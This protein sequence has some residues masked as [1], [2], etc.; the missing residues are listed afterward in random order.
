MMKLILGIIVTSIQH[1]K[2][3]VLLQAECT[4]AV[5]VLEELGKRSDS[6][7]DILVSKCL[8]TLGELMGIFILSPSAS[9][10]DCLRVFESAI[11]FFATTGYVNR[12][13]DR[14]DMWMAREEFMEPSGMMDMFEDLKALKALLFSDQATRTNDTYH[15]VFKYI[16]AIV[17]NGITYSPVLR[18]NA[19]FFLELGCLSSQLHSSAHQGEMVNTALCH[20][21]EDTTWH[22]MRWIAALAHRNSSE[23]MLVSEFVL[24][25]IISG[26]SILEP[27]LLTELLDAL[28]YLL[29]CSKSKEVVLVSPHVRDLQSVVWE[30]IYAAVAHLDSG[31]KNYGIAVSL[32]GII[33]SLL[34]SLS[35]E[36]FSIRS[37]QNGGDLLVR[38]CLG[39]LD[40][41]FLDSSVGL[42]KCALMEEVLQATSA[43]LQSCIQLGSE[44]AG[45]I[46][47]H[48]ATQRAFCMPVGTK[49]IENIA[50]VNWC[51][52]VLG[53]CIQ[54]HG[55]LYAEQLLNL[56]PN[57]TRLLVRLVSAIAQNTES[58]PWDSVAACISMENGSPE[59]MGWQE[60]CSALFEQVFHRTKCLVHEQATVTR[61]ATVNVHISDTIA[62]LSFKYGQ[63][64]LD[65]SRNEEAC[66]DAIIRSGL[67]FL[68]L[69]R[70]ASSFGVL[71]Y[72]AI[73]SLHLKI[74]RLVGFS[75]QIERSNIEETATR[76][77]QL[78]SPVSVSDEVLADYLDLVT[79]MYLST[80]I[81]AA[82]WIFIEAAG[83]VWSISMERLTTGLVRSQTLE[84]SLLKCVSSLRNEYAARWESGEIESALKLVKIFSPD[85]W[86]QQ[87]L[88]QSVLMLPQGLLHLFELARAAKSSET[89]LMIMYFLFQHVD[90]IQL[91]TQRI[92]E[93]EINMILS[94]IRRN[95][96]GRVGDTCQRKWGQVTGSEFLRSA[97]ETLELF[98]RRKSYAILCS[99]LRGVATLYDVLCAPSQYQGT[100]KVALEICCCLAGHGAN[101]TQENSPFVLQLL[102]ISVDYHV[103]SY[104][105]RFAFL[106]LEYFLAHGI[107][108][109]T[110]PMIQQC[111]TQIVPQSARSNEEG[112]FIQ[113]L[114][115][116][117]QKIARISRPPA[118]NGAPASQ[119]SLNDGEICEI[120]ISNCRR[121]VQCSNGKDGLEYIDFYS[122]E[123][124]LVEP[125]EYSRLRE[126][127]DQLS[128]ILDDLDMV[129][130]YSYVSPLVPAL[131]ETLALHTNTTATMCTVMQILDQ[132]SFVNPSI[133]VFNKH[134][135][136]PALFASFSLHQR[137]SLEFARYLSRFCN[138]VTADLRGN[139]EELAISLLPLLL[140]LLQH[141][142][143]DFEIVDQ[144]LATLSNFLDIMRIEEFQFR[145]SGDILA[146]TNASVI[147]YISNTLSSW[148]WIKCTFT[149]VN[150]LDKLGIESVQ[151]TVAT[152]IR[153]IHMFMSHN[154][155]VEKAVLVLIL[156]YVETRQLPF[157]HLIESDAV[158]MLLTCLKLNVNNGSIARSCLKLLVSLT[159]V[160]DTATQGVSHLL[161]SATASSIILVARKNFDNSLIC[162]MCIE[163]IHR[164]VESFSKYS[165]KSHK[166]S[167][168]GDLSRKKAELLTSL[169][170]ADIIPLI[171]DL[172][173]NYSS[174]GHD[175]LLEMLLLLLK[176]LTKDES[177]RES[178]EV[179][180]GLH[181][182]KQTIDRARKYQLDG[183]LVELAI[184]CLVNLA[185]SDRSMGHEWREISLWL[186]ELAESIHNLK[187]DSTGMCVE[188]L[189]GV[190]GRL[191]VDSAICK[192]ILPKGSFTIL[193]L[194]ATVGSDYPLEQ[195]LYGLLCS[196][197]DDI[198]CAQVLI[199]VGAIKTTAE[200]IFC[201]IYDEETLLCSLCFLDLLVLNCSESYAVLLD[202]VVFQALDLVICTYPET[203]GSPLHHLSSTIREKVSALDYQ[204]TRTK[205]VTPTSAKIPAPQ[206]QNP[207]FDRPFRDLLRA[208]GTFQVLWEARPGAVEK[209]QI[210]LA[211]SGD[212]LLFRRQTSTQLSRIE[213]I[214]V[215][216]VEVCPQRSLNAESPPS[217]SKKILSQSISKEN[218]AGDRVLRLKVRGEDVLIKTNS[219][220]ERVHWDQ[221][222]QWLVSHRDS[223]K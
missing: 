193:E 86:S 178:A 124:S 132:I 58:F 11:R 120:I 98:V 9:A 125:V 135:K 81:Q 200:R 215:S 219:T 34:S 119:K 156:V 57:P 23:F 210:K 73:V 136:V 206:G 101:L 32:L 36:L 70:A 28:N 160:S 218:F 184:D 144:N 196:L 194:L 31:S 15:N 53:A 40:I 116:I 138:S 102:L 128:F 44:Y 59:T 19:H 100:V 111:R 46:V 71:E 96:A 177:L 223:H 195:A 77:R 110:L 82:P 172:L 83:Q 89:H 185:C 158:E 74:A 37:K 147:P 85:K 130:N 56:S 208:G 207:D 106:V 55:L 169:L 43:I 79:T 198:E 117:R 131:C 27:A 209:I 202:G 20:F 18:D 33:S 69:F 41:F 21:A 191:S 171:F 145:H 214:F 201:H 4:G 203:S 133:V 13:M 114:Y 51:V 84:K 182:L 80:S 190:L 164:M 25:R 121:F 88:M 152:V 123:K 118:S 22:S 146:L 127:I 12:L 92:G 216:Q 162:G 47:Q 8:G 64:C 62:L 39:A 72:S 68:D 143:L 63:L 66:L 175:H 3:C 148:H 91:K 16:A 167:V 14:L 221:A 109:L 75:T 61:S 161:T 166:V 211:P 159:S 173:D 157:R 176:S 67:S 222:L 217:P 38:F 5:R 170:E 94:L 97:L 104:R 151:D 7:A 99:D 179:L 107:S 149:I 78:L 24:L 113:Q 60:P 126:A 134:A 140:E 212:Y 29:R 48:Q 26:Y 30:L 199:V 154:F 2:I 163:L 183:A 129:M 6:I 115:I 220:R 112:V 141:W 137:S 49:T 174:R 155:M 192:T 189:I 42:T 65:T 103:D 35:G 54:S 181:E 165:E 45:S 142:K 186:L 52:V 139:D 150:K 93:L 90:E 50:C 153:I 76:I 205:P 168:P 188:K 197:C 180:H 108:D 122:S 105:S 17:E 1:K 87:L 10:Q 213:R 187:S 204:S 95:V